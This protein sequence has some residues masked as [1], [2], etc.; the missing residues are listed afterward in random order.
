MVQDD[1]TQ[2]YYYWNLVT[3]EVTWEIPPGYTQFLLLYKEYEERIAKIPKDK[4]QRMKERKERKKWVYVM[5]CFVLILHMCVR[6]CVI[7]EHITKNPQRHNLHRIMET[8][9]EEKVDIN[10]YF[11]SLVLL[12]N[13]FLCV[14]AHK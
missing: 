14:C 9:R 4:L 12:G 11:T 10:Y 13:L 5:T 1:A 2:Y 3:N 6:V 8:K 7:E